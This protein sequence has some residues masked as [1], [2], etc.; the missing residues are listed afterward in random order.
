MILFRNGYYYCHVMSKYTFPL[1]FLKWSLHAC[2]ISLEYSNDYFFYILA[3]S[4]ELYC[5][6]STTVG[7][8]TYLYV[9]NTD[10]TTDESTTYRFTCYVSTI[11][12]IK[13]TRY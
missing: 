8:Y 13:D 4:G 2:N 10:T 1:T 6:H 11:I 3:A 9:Y 5:L 7:S 12:P